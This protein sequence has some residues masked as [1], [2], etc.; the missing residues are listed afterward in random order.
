MRRL[1]DRVYD[2]VLNVTNQFRKLDEMSRD[3]SVSQ[4]S[5][6]A[7]IEQVNKAFEAQ[8]R[9]ARYAAFGLEDHYKRVADAEKRA[10]EAE[11]KK[12]DAAEAATRRQASQDWRR[13]KPQGMGQYA[14]RNLGALTPLGTLSPS[15][16]GC[17]RP[18]SMT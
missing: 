16:I 9:A 5:L 12:R 13:I 3:N 7:Q 8:R 18:I 15:T 1:F 10:A 2:S 6:A 14:A 4:E 11:K 17:F